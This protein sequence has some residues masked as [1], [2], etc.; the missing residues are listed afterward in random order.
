M[1]ASGARVPV[2]LGRDGV[3]GPKYIEPALRRAA[4]GDVK[5]ACLHDCSV[6]FDHEKDLFGAAMVRDA[7]GQFTVP[8]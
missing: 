2:W 8:F 7:L 5:R 1:S 4:L 3:P 6:L